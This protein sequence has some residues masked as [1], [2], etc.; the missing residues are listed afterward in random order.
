MN[1]YR[2]WAYDLIARWEGGKRENLTFKN[3]ET[4]RAAI[5]ADEAD[6]RKVMIE[7]GHINTETGEVTHG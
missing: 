1:A 7:A 3:Y 6:A 5:R 4:A 2:S